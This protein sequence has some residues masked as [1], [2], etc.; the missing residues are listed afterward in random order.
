MSKE[1]LERELIKI[2]WIKMKAVLIGI[3]IALAVLISVYIK[4]IR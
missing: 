3:A 2:D 4:L 1:K